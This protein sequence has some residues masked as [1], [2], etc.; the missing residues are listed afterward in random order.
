MEQEI[1]AAAKWWTELISKPV[2]MDS[3]DPGT[4]SMILK[5][6][7][8][9]Q[10]LPTPEQLDTFR[11]TL[12]NGLRAEIVSEKRSDYLVFLNVDYDR[13]AVLEGAAVAAGLAYMRFPCKTVMN[14][15]PGSILVA[16]GYGAPFVEIL[17]KPSASSV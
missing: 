5:L 2:T 3:G 10:R 1:K 14:I 4:T 11:E 17:A 6:A 12:E 8:D 16:E 15:Q 9:G 7:A 13:C